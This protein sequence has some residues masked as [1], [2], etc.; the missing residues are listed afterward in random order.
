LE[1]IGAEIVEVR[2]ED[3]RP[4]LGALRARGVARDDA[5]TVGS[6]VTIPLHGFDARDAIDVIDELT[7]GAG[8][9]TVR[10]TTL[11][12]VYL[13]LTTKEMQ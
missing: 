6:T 9:V 1:A 7:G 3:A 12:D 10:P 8:G 13:R 11:D 2:V 4:L 5:F